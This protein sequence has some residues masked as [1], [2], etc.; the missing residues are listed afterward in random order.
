MEMPGSFPAHDLDDLGVTI[1][2][3]RHATIAGIVLEELGEIP[4]VGETV[5][6]GP[7]L[8]TVLE[9]TDRAILRVRLERLPGDDET[10][11]EDGRAAGEPAVEDIELRPE[12]VL[13]V[14]PTV[15]DRIAQVGAVPPTTVTPIEGPP[16]NR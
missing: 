12:H 7:W 10:A 2:P 14:E 9:V 3:G 15:G 16:Q 6:V 5:R 1:D 8:A 4:E 11:G 13:V